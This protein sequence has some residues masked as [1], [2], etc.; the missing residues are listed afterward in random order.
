LAAT[1][2]VVEETARDAD[3]FGRLLDSK[4]PRLSAPSFSVSGLLLGH[5]ILAS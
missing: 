2:K 3:E 1:D 5:N 4:E